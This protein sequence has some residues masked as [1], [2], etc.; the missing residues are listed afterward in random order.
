MTLTSGM[1][2]SF[3]C[4]LQLPSNQTCDFASSMQKI[5]QGKTLILDRLANIDRQLR[6]VSSSQIDQSTVFLGHYKKGDR[7]GHLAWLQLSNST[8]NNIGFYKA[9][10]YSQIIATNDTILYDNKL[11]AN[12][13]PKCSLKSTGAAKYDCL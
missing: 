1:E 13:Q 6:L 3:L 11:L 4:R 10:P 9:N 7:Q 2:T 8:L 12:P 5:S